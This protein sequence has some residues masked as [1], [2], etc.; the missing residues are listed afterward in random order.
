MTS[1]STDFCTPWNLDFEQDGTEDIAV[2]RDAESDEI[3]SSR[4]FWLPVGD[5]PVPP[6]LAA[7]RLM[8]AAPKLLAACK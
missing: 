2:I 6:T 3:V 8:A 4:P 5:D 1:L 7:L